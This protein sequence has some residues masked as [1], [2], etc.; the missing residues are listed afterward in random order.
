[1]SYAQSRGCDMVFK[2]TQTLISGCVNRIAKCKQTFFF[3]VSFFQFN[4][5]RTLSADWG[6]KYKESTNITAPP[7][8]S[9]WFF[10]SNDAPNT[11]NWN[12]ECKM[13]LVWRLLGFGMDSGAPSASQPQHDICCSGVA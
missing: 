10:T 9:H 11:E 6:Q 13:R 12:V 1:M 5:F 7:V 4:F 2:C 8:R 3:F